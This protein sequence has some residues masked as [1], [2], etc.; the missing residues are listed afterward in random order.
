M[1]LYHGAVA[2]G[3]QCPICQEAFGETE[4]VLGHGKDLANLQHHVH[5]ACAR[6]FAK[7]D[8]RCSV[9]REAVDLRRHFSPDELRELADKRA[10]NALGD[11]AEQDADDAAAAHQFAIDDGAGAGLPANGIDPAS[12]AL[13]AELTEEGGDYQNG[14]AGAGGFAEEAIASQNGMSPDDVLAAAL[15]ASRHDAPAGAGVGF[16]NT[17][18]V[19]D[20][21]AAI[22]A[23][24]QDPRAGAGSAA[25]VHHPVPV[26]VVLPAPAAAGGVA[27]AMRDGCNRALL[28]L[29]GVA[30]AVATVALSMLMQRD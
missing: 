27:P 24:L 13:I 11:K 25:I 15:A 21:D 20:I 19:D 29:A 1:S 14:F 9:C 7:R 12:A 16:D 10:A 3:A 17:P 18:P 26:P 28:A 8:D 22:L 5:V 30:G 4:G 23:S 2:P 6:E